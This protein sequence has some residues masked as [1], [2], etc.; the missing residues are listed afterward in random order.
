MVKSY[1][2]IRTALFLASAV[3]L[4]NLAFQNC[5]PVQFSDMTAEARA[6]EAERIAIGADREVITAGLNQMPDLKLFFV[7]DNSG[8]M[9]QNQLNLSASFGSMFD[10]SSSSL[11]KFD[12]TTYLLNT[13]QTSPSISS[14]KSVL[15][16]IAGQ[17]SNFSLSAL[18]PQAAFETDVRTS[19]LNLGYLPGDNVGYQ[20]KKIASPLSYQFLP[21]TVLG[22]HAD[23]GQISLSNSI[24]KTAAVDVAAT[25]Q[26]FK[27]RLAILSSDRIPQVLVGSTYRP[28]NY[29]VIDN[30]SGLCA[31]SRILRNPQLYIKAGDLLSFTIVSDENDNDPS[32]SK[33]IQSVT[34]YDGTEDLV[35]GDCKFKETQLSYQ[36]QST[37]QK[38]SDC[39]ISGNAGYNYKFTYPT[40]SYTTAVTYKHIKTA[41]VYKAYYY[42]LQYT[43]L[44]NVYS[45]LNTDITYYVQICNDVYSDG[46]KTGTKCVIDPVSKSGSK[47][48]DYVDATMCYGLAKSLNTNAVNDSGYKPVCTTSYKS[49][50]TACSTADPLC[51]VATT[52]KLNSVNNI[53]GVNSAATCLTKA[54]S[55]ADYSKNAICSDASKNVASCSV[56]ESAARCD[57]ISGAIYDTKSEIAGGD[58]TVDGCLSWAK[59]RAG[60]AVLSLSDITNCTKNTVNGLATYTNSLNFS[61]TKALDGGVTLPVGVS[62]SCGVLKSLAYAKA[63]TAIQAV[64]NDDC[65]LT[66]IKAASVITEVLTAGNCSAQAVNKCNIS[67]NRNCSG[68]EIT[69]PATTTTNPTVYNDVKVKE[70][71]SCSTLCSD[72]KL[73]VCGAN[74]GVGLTIDGYLKNKYGPAI[75]CGATTS[76]SELNKEPLVAKLQSQESLLCAPT[77]AG[78]PRFFF[79][80]KGPYRSQ[81]LI[82]DYVSGTKKGTDNQDQVVPLV[83]FIKSKV[84]QMSSTNQVLF[85]ALVRK[86]TD[87]LGQGGTVGVD[88]K[89]LIDQTQGQLDS[90]LS[91]DYSVA[92]KELSKVIKNSLERSFILKKM[93]PDQIITKVFLIKKDTKAVVELAKS[94]WTQSAGT[95]KI[96]EG[97]E[98]VDGDEF[99]ID[100]QNNIPKK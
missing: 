56:A 29:S 90:V 78:E 66:S 3:F 19:S 52:E 6:L 21:A 61:E 36:T 38:P 25:E 27:E 11:S 53:L 16:K 98:F 64:K 93:R 81:S 70:P 55:Y 75:V 33:C 14:E 77:I 22:V 60:N 7:V 48:G 62:A 85:S 74:P 88:Y 71:L 73:A 28:E 43:S 68:A 95:L 12:S 2:Y 96:S 34:Q 58:Q 51:K 30:E 89:S 17:Q 49:R 10:S 45:Y 32:G 59:G 37:S 54:Q 83:E 26:E 92:L 13:A 97:L 100:F 76:I 72:S 79:R 82:T 39:K 18:I 86:S 9:K 87:P 1:K 8:T 42:N 5:S 20:V 4:L 23:S 94:D 40:T 57:L 84:Q 24:R 69:Y 80:T 41:A 65:V 44:V 67:F 35:D 91:P 46:I 31:V 99:Q 15:D 47:D 63:S 50:S